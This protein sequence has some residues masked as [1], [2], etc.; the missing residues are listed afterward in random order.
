MAALEAAY[1]NRCGEVRHPTSGAELVSK[2]SWARQMDRLA[3]VVLP[4]MV[5][6]D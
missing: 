3:G 4:Y 1:E 5:V 6:G 2:L